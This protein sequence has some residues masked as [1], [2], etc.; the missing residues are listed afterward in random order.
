MV[1]V[2]LFRLKGTSIPE[3]DGPTYNDVKGIG[4]LENFDPAHS[5]HY[6]SQRPRVE[7]RYYHRGINMWRLPY[8]SENSSRNQ[9]AGNSKVMRVC[10]Y[11][12]NTMMSQFT[13]IA[14]Q[15][16]SC[17]YAHQSR[18]GLFDQP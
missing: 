10:T 3:F 9:L 17:V 11:I 15:T 8:V 1:I 7:I 16:S 14:P 18:R 12:V 2:N 13:H 4:V 6:L 5:I